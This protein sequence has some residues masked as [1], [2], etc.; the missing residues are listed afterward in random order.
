MHL[1]G[2][3]EG[4][5]DNGRELIL[6]SADF[7]RAYLTERWAS[8]FITEL[9]QYFNVLFIGYSINDP[10][11]AYMLDALAAEIARGGAVGKAYGFA[12]FEVAP[13]AVTE[14]R[15]SGSQRT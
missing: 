5:N 1:H 12:P 14:R 13:V 6:T 7:D 11:L 4:A 9:F 3:I 15:S 2:R 8:R 10:V